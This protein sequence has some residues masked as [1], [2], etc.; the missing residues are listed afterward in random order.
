MTQVVAGQLA[1]DFT[2]KDNHGTPVTLSALHGKNV[3][4][5]FIP[6]AFSG[7]C[8]GELCE[9]RDNLSLF[10]SVDVTLLVISCDPMFAQKAWAEQE[11]Y[12]FPFLSDFWPHGQ[13]A[14]QYGVFDSENGLALRGSFLIDALGTVRWSVLNPRG[15]ARDF[16]GYRKALTNLTA[17]PT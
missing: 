9:L 4:L 12:Q 5:V 2:L 13:V 7:I 1:P 8:T 17:L 3:L 14:E 16:S 6:F 15:Q 10:E 11:N